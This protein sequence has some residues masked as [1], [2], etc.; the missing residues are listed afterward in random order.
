[1]AAPDA[2]KELALT[3]A[4]VGLNTF[5]FVGEP[6]TPGQTL[7][8]PRSGTEYGP[9]VIPEA[10]KHAQVAD[11]CRLVAPRS[12]AETAYAEG[13]QSI[14]LQDKSAVLRVDP[15]TRRPAAVILA[16][17]RLLTSGEIGFVPVYRS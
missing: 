12:M 14:G 7:A 4:A 16:S 17:A 8:W 10:V 6:E 2:V 3:Q 15:S 1:L 13:F 5:G 9:G 11:A